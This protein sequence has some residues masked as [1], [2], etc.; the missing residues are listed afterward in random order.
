MSSL[1]LSDGT[2]DP[3]FASGTTSYTVSITNDISSISV[4]PTVA[5][6][7]ATVKVNGTPVTSGSPSDALD[8]AVGDNTIAM[9]VTAQDGTTKTYTVTVTRSEAPVVLSSNADLSSLVFSEG[10]LN[11]EFAVN[12]T[13]YTAIVANEVNSLTV[14]PNVAES[15]ATVKVNGTLVTSGNCSDAIDLAVGDNTITM[16]VTAQDATT[17]TYTITVTRAGSGNADLSSL[18][19]RNGDSDPEDANIYSLYPEFAADTLSYIVMV[20]VSSVTV[21]PEVA[22]PN[23]TIRVNGKLVESGSESGA[24]NLVE[25]ENI[26]RVRVTAQDGTIKKYTITCITQVSAVEHSVPA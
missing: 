20:Y 16:L 26:I 5:E 21:K 9:L 8:L 3:V 4:T 22:E 2:L 18:I 6:S 24:I 1:V 13:S 15:H 10:T 7:N 12:T 14:T 23:A 11:P 25:G 19:L 17:K